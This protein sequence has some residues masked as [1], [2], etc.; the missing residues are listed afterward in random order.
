MTTVETN[1]MHG[2]TEIVKLTVLIAMA[3]FAIGLILSAVTLSDVLKHLGKII[4]I[5]ILLLVLPAIMVNLWST[6]SYWQHLG[7]LI[8]GSMAGLSLRA[9]LQMHV[10][11]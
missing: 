4:S 6:V 8:L 7:T 11:K 9:L 2:W 3:I 1:L 5:V 10:K